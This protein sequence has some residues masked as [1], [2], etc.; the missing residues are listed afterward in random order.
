MA[1]VEKF[2]N[3]ISV[4]KQINHVE[5]LVRGEY[6]NTD[7][8]KDRICNDY[9]LI[10]RDIPSY[11]YYTQRLSQCRIQNRKDIKTAFGWIITKPKDVPPEKEFLFFKHCY[12]FLCERYG[13]EENCITATVHK[14][15]SKDGES[16][17]HYLGIPAVAN[18]KKT[19]VN[20]QDERINM[21][22]VINRKDLRSFH[23]DL[24]NYLKSKGMICS[25]YTGVTAKQGGNKTVKQLKAEREIKKEMEQKQ[26]ERKWQHIY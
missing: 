10:E 25:V 5:R 19:A 15:E 24:D 4:S 18:N 20:N 1:S 3:R 22:A 12:N 21:S 9:T 2:G 16:H 8:D 11:D 17:M 26:N 23:K 14:D 6:G 7:I 13:G